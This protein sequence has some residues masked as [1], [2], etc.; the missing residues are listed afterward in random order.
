[1]YVSNIRRKARDVRVGV[2]HQSLDL[3]VPAC[4][5]EGS[6][7]LSVSVPAVN[8]VRWALSS[9]DRVRRW[10]SSGPSTSRRVLAADHM[11]ARGWSALKPPG[12]GRGWR[13]AACEVIMSGGSWVAMALQERR[14]HVSRIILTS[15]VYLDGKV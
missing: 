5:T 8:A 3:P 1:M 14:C 13:R 7:S 4:C 9:F 2:E 6:R 12:E 10:T 11:A 15:S